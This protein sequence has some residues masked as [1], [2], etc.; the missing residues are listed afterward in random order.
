MEFI[1]K[2]L[3]GTALPIAIL[4]CSIY[5]L[6]KLRGR[7]IVNPIAIVRSLFNKSNSNGVSPIKA[8]IF[9]L[10]GTLGVG[11]IVGVASA[12]SLGG[13]GSVFWM[14]ISA[15]LAMILKYSEVVLAVKHRRTRNGEN[16][17][18]AMYYMRDYFNSCKKHTLG[19]VLTLIFILLCLVNGLTMGCIIQSNAIS[20]ACKMTFGADGFAIGLI[21][22]IMSFTVF[23][24]NGKKVFSICEKLVPFVSFLYIGMCLAV[25]AARYDKLPGVLEEIINDAFSFQSVGAGAMGFA[26]SKSLRYGTVRGLFSNEAGCGTSPIA[27]ATANTSSPCEQGFLGVVEVFID[28]MLVCTLTA[29]VILLNPKENFNY[30]NAPMM[31]VMNS[32]SNVLGNISNL[33]LS[34]SVVLFAF[35]TIICWGYYGRECVYYFNKSA[36]ATKLYYI[37]YIAFVFAGSI[38]SLDLVWQLADFAV[39]GMTLINLSILVLMNKEIKTETESY[40]KKRASR[41]KL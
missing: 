13:A 10:A 29:F 16:F 33:L 24:L 22:V 28:T 17:G 14:W 4:V 8:V 25:I 19:Y 18:G 23:F 39:A 15:F 35:A 12:I 2:Y 7:P 1:N 26:V 27:H 3:S 34:A 11:N 38:I 30:G 40:F 9:A 31:M 5:F 41:R 20:E 21:L 37:L 32:F 36:K 6:V